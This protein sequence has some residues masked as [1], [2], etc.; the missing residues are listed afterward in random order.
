MPS[1]RSFIIAPLALLTISLQAMTLSSQLSF[2]DS[3]LSFKGRT[4]LTPN[5][6]T[7]ATDENYSG[8]GIAST[9]AHHVPLGFVSANLQLEG[10]YSKLIGLYG[11][12]GSDYSLDNTQLFASG[13]LHI[14]PNN[15]NP[16][17]G[18][19][20]FYTAQNAARIGIG[21]KLGYL[22]YELTS[23]NTGTL[24]NGY[25]EISAKNLSAFPTHVKL[26]LSLPVSERMHGFFDFNYGLN[27]LSSTLPFNPKI[28]S[29]HFNNSALLANP[30]AS[31]E[32]KA[33]YIGDYYGPSADIVLNKLSVGLKIDIKDI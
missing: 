22:G 13:S 11:E 29:H 26:H 6:A 3:Q 16:F 9:A 1:T 4:Q 20:A 21:L 18:L 12:I 24:F 27:L 33:R 30:N 2:S 10:A 28:G 32:T 7:S 8:K 14:K 15:H 17:I 25:D 5:Y 19:G 31:D 23:D